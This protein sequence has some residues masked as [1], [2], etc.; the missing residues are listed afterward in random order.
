MALTCNQASPATSVHIVR[1][2][3]PPDSFL[4]RREVR[5]VTNGS[6]QTLGHFPVPAKCKFKNEMYDLEAVVSITHKKGT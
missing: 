1:E 2:A 4:V 6:Q 5:G 3:R